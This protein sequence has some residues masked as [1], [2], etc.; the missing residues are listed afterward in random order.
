MVFFSALL[1]SASTFSND[2][3][4]EV[5]I[6]LTRVVSD[7][8]KVSIVVPPIQ[9]DVIEF[10]MP[11]IVPGTY[12]ISDF[13]RFVS[14][15]RALDE[16][17]GALTV[18]RLDKN[19]WEISGATKLHSISYWIEDTFDTSKPSKI[20]EPGGTNFEEGKNFTL[21]PFGICGYIKDMQN[22]EYK[23]NFI[24]SKDHFGSSALQK[25]VISE[26]EDQ[27]TASNYFDLSDAPIMYCAPD[28]ATIPVGNCMVQI[29]VYSPNGVLNAQSVKE[30]IS[31]TLEAQRK[32]LGG[33]L[34]V[35]RYAVLIYLFDGQS[36]S[37]GAGALEHSYSTLLCLPEA[38]IEALGQTFKDVT[39]HEFFHI[40][41]PL[42]IHSEHIHDYDFINPS[43]SQHLWLYE[44]VTEY[45]AHH[46]QV[47]D[48]QITDHQFL[49]VIRQKMAT[50]EFYKQDLPFTELSTGALD[51]HESQYGNVYQKGALIGMCLDLMLLDKSEGTYSLQEL[52]KDLSKTYGKNRAF[53][54]EQLFDIITGMTYEEVGAFLRTHVAGNTPLPYIDL[55]DKAGVVYSPEKEIKD[56]N[57]GQVGFKWVPEGFQ[58]DYAL[59]PS[60]LYHGLKLKTGDVLVGIDGTPFAE[61]EDIKDQ[62]NRMLESVP[63][64]KKFKLQVIK[65]G[66]GKV[67]NTKGKVGEQTTKNVK[68]ALSFKEDATERQLRIRK[69]WLN[70][71][72]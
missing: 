25:E 18:K 31:S 66:K 59:N 47:R 42:N 48:Q 53:E 16:T 7:K 11:K 20:F 4:Y 67:S 3:G 1:F 64:G 55:L 72:D 58:I 21:N 70:Q 45:S 68:H 12:S 2:G 6:D 37:G 15:F 26:T 50:S 8:I 62:M 35:D 13:G 5:S 10:Q 39:A 54:D 41:T 51:K 46:A 9:D 52:L 63:N 17:K 36:N 28:T 24:H 22:M 27:F 29:S 38:P 65:G 32:Y 34:P 49:N 40:V 44:G 30:S 14:S 61:G 56:F 60:E 19:R 57:L 69:A 43:M 23:V 71:K 33:D